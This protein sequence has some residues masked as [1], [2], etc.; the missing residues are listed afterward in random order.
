MM[1]KPAFIKLIDIPDGWSE[2]SADF[3]N[4]LLQRKPE[5]RLGFKGTTEVK[6]H[7]W[8][9][10]YPWEKL[11]DKRIDS[12][13]I[14]EKKD[15][16]DKRYC[17]SIDVI[18]FETKGRYEQYKNY[19]N[20]NSIFQNFTYYGIIDKVIQVSPPFRKSRTKSISP[21][22]S[23]SNFKNNYS[24]NKS[25]PASVTPKRDQKHNNKVINR[26]YTNI[27]LLMK[28]ESRNKSTHLSL[29]NNYYNKSAN[30]KNPWAK[31]R[32]MNQTRS[33][34]KM[35]SRENTPT[36]QVHRISS[37][38]TSPINYSRRYMNKKTR[39]I[40]GGY[41]NQKLMA[42]QS[43]S[44]LMKYMRNS[45]ENI[46]NKPLRKNNINYGGRV[47]KV[48]ICFQSQKSFNISGDEF[49]CSNNFGMNDQKILNSS[50]IIS[51]VPNKK[52]LIS[53][54][55]KI[56]ETNSSSHNNSIIPL[57]NSIKNHNCKE[58]KQSHS[59]NYFF[60]NKNIS[61]SSHS[62]SSSAGTYK[63]KNGKS[64]NI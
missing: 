8:L 50:H 62:T 7:F 10:S 42:F 23:S 29:S 55:K 48:P 21:S 20:F 18:G 33:K 56:T 38:I 27:A 41:L 51:R 36:I 13:F 5:A 26:S 60:K 64:K 63:I 4:K 24:S 49:S 58:F 30:I 54:S 45:S 19:S 15:N 44:S 53:S 43:K 2:E 22:S 1:A 52:K 40:E 3:I 39:A 11:K 31:T 35:I 61:I 59:M 9:Q 25:R 14:P 32:S 17:E 37:L 28:N 16:Y 47:T 6:S 12:P 34:S 57:T 46:N